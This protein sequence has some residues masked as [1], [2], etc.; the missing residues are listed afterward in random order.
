[1]AVPKA[2]LTVRI[3]APLRGELSRASELEHQSLS[4]F[5]RLLLEYAW[6]KYLRAG[7][8]RE[9]LTRQSETTPRRE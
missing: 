3:D 9:L 1:M 4:N 2:Y 6:G 8:L 7:S 5:S